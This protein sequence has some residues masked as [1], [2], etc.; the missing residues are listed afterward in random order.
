M[1]WK[2][3]D[4]YA[5]Q[6][7][8]ALYRELSEKAPLH[9][10]FKAALMYIRQQEAATLQEQRQFNHLPFQWL[11]PQLYW[12]Q[13]IS[14]LVDWNTPY[15]SAKTKAF[16]HISAPNLILEKPDNQVYFFRG[17]RQE[18]KRLLPKLMK[19]ETIL[20]TGQGGL[21]K[22]AM[23]E[24]LIR[25]KLA[26]QPDTRYFFFD[27]KNLKAIT[28]LNTI[29]E[30]L[31]IDYQAFDEINGLANLNTAAQKWASILRS[32]QT[33]CHPLFIFDNLESFQTGPH[34]TFP[35]AQK[36]LLT[37]I[38]ILHHT[39]GIG[40]ILTSRYPISEIDTLTPTSL[41]QVSLN[42]FWK[43][44]GDLGIGQWRQHIQ[45]VKQQERLAPTWKQNLSY[46][47]IVKL[48]RDKFGG[49]YRALEWFDGLIQE[50]K[51]ATDSALNTIAGFEDVIH[52]E[53]SQ[54][55]RDMQGNLRF[56]ALFHL[57]NHT[58]QRYIQILAQ[59]Q[60]PVM[61]RALHAQLNEKPNAHT[62]TRLVNMTL[63][64][65]YPTGYYCPPLVRTYVQHTSIVHPFD[66][67]KAGHYYLYCIENTPDD[68]IGFHELAFFHFSE[69]KD[70]AQI[71]QLGEVLSS[72]FWQADLNSQALQYASLTYAICQENINPKTLNRLGQLYHH[73]GQLSQAL[74]C[75]QTNL[76]FYQTQS[77]KAGEGTTLNNISQIFKARGDYDT[78][79]Q[80]LEQSLS[81]QRQIGDKAG[82]G[83]TLNN[84]A[85]TAYAKGDYDT[86]LQYLEQSLIIWRQ[87][88]DKAGEGTTLNNISQIFKARGD[89]DTALQYLEQSLVIRRQIGDKAGEGTT[90]N[91]ISQ[92][93]KA[94]GDYDTALQY[95]EQSLVIRRQIGDKAGEGTTLNNISQIFKARGD[96]DTALQ[97]L[98]QSLVIKRQ[99]GDK[100]GE[101]TTLNNI[102]Q[103]FKARGDYDTALQYLEQSLSIQRQI[104]DKAGEGTTLNNIS[105]IFDA[106][107]DYD[108]A[109]QYLEQSLVIRRQIGDKA[110]E[111]TTLNNI[112][113]IFKARG[114]YDTALQYL[115]QSLSI[116][117]QIG[118]KAGE[119]TTLNNLAGISRAKGDYDTALQYLEQSLVIRRQIGD[120]AGEG[121]TLNN[122]AG[123]SRA[124][125][126]Y[127]TALQYLEQSL[128]IRRQIGDKAGEG[129]TL[130]NI[131]QIF[132]A[133]GD[134]DTALQYLEQSLSIQ[135]QIGD[136]AG[137]GTTLN[138]I[139]QIFDAKGDY[140]TALQ[141]LEQSLSIQRQIGDK[142]GEGTTLNNISQIFDA[143]GDYDT[144]LQYLEQSLSIQRQ[145]GDK[146]GELP[147][148]H[149]MAMIS[150]EQADMK[151]YLEYEIQAY[152]NALA[153]GDQYAI[154]AIGQVF[155]SVLCQLGEKELGL[156]ILKQALAICQQS[157][158]PNCG[159]IQN[160][161]NQCTQK[162]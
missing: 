69:T 41:N 109:L 12:Q 8:A 89:Y 86:A 107:G 139:S 23:A 39:D 34:H 106:K 126:D 152:Q 17:R 60:S 100:A 75:Y 149:N 95:L 54:V 65:K 70:E 93:F 2:I 122:L 82:E 159:D 13:P 150:L 131:S 29:K 129:T 59:F 138:N 161:I 45:E 108:T 5:T 88:G 104:G 145:I 64:E 102:S 121:T 1:G 94:R 127:D 58:E 57:L 11:I 73:D 48:L 25:R 21:G 40:L 27:E 162:S 110:G 83:T 92:I 91:N 105:Q 146:A 32:L 14:H 113:Q 43:K 31:L 147:T 79:L 120:K 98:E 119:G 7:T 28:L 141:Y 22:T 24:Y 74:A 78:A 135:R 55:Q 96:Y 66:H 35:A 71:K 50:K 37:F 114:D 76:K 15:T 62:L 156:N 153:I 142:A 19:D 30:T 115:E 46:L 63:L 36:D 38:Q 112:S 20:L 85:T 61:D 157:G 125:G 144:A 111:G 133:R 160:V 101:G 18:R 72:F 87:I 155:G 148:L 47:D 81:I 151:Q 99:I 132:K 67:D 3:F 116:Q 134:Y 68:T 140:D 130:N 136:K 52:Q 56:E 53:V 4:Q 137:E 123:I 154:F 33:E 49:N 9:R 80:Y 10:A 103:I 44:C 42:D 124:K 118:D 97:Y 6:F 143:K 84:L 158:L 128:V 26:Y 77:D 16:T 90:L 51:E 117:R